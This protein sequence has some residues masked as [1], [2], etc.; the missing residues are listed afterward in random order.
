MWLRNK[1]DTQ[2]FK[3]DDQDRTADVGEPGTTD[4]NPTG[5]STTGEG[6]PI[7]SQVREAVDDI[8]QRT[9]DE[10]HQD[11][12]VVREYEQRYSGARSR[13]SRLELPVEEPSAGVYM[14][15]KTKRRTDVD[16]NERKWAALAHSSTLLTAL[17][18]LASGGAGVLLT[19]FIPLFIYF[20]FRKR[21]EYVAFHALQAFTIQLIGTVGWLALL[22]TGLVVWV[23]LIILSAI[24]ILVLV[25]IVLLPLVALM[26]PIFILSS[27]ALPVG[28]VIYSVI[29]AVETWNGRDYRYP[30][31]ARWVESQMHGSMLS[32]F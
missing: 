19:I 1:Y 29:A 11:E 23:A 25:G 14:P 10:A 16:V 6:V 13:R 32:I 21:S 8:R 15:A 31:I 17:V 24:L 28:M 27:L 18:G 5:E 3:M 26:L 7:P 22:I 9:R 2:E 12:D 30:Y 20:A 4:Q